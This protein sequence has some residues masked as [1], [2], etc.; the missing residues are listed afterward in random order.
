MEDNVIELPG[1]FNSPMDLEELVKK[2]KTKCP[3]I[4][5][6]LFCNV[7]GF[8]HLGCHHPDFHESCGFKKNMNVH[9]EQ[10]S[11]CAG[12]KRLFN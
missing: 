3:Y 6:A 5:P 10:R 7:G 4:S 8:G 9:I 1:F 2:K 12:V 11:I